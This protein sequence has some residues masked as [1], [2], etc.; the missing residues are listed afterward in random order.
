MQYIQY[1][2]FRLL[3]LLISWL[4]AHLLYRLAD[5]V[6]WV[7]YRVVKYRLPTVRQNLLLVFPHKS[8]AERLQIEQGFYKNLGDVFVEGVWGFSLSVAEMVS[9]YKAINPE[10]LTPYFEQ[11]RSVI[12]AGSHYVNWEWGATCAAPQVAHPPIGLYKP[13][14]NP[15]IDQLLRRSRAKFDMTLVSI[16]DTQ[17]TFERYHQAKRAF[18]MLSDQRP[19]KKRNAYWMKFLGQETACLMGVERYA[20]QYNLPVFYVRQQRVKR[21]YYTFELIPLEMHP[22]QSEK[23][24]ITRQFMQTLEQ[25]ILEEPAGW[26][27]SHKR[28]K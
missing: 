8:E 20:K 24:A 9:R 14:S 21:G 1:F 16:E 22:S 6:T 18:V 17:T 2:F 5:F 15:K 7:L 12:V 3:V 27:W 10:I 11:G 19:F 4:P 26:L 13:L 25:I 23:G 28:W